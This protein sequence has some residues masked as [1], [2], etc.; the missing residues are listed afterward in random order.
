MTHALML[1]TAFRVLRI[2]LPLC[3]SGYLVSCHP[4]TDEEIK[5]TQIRVV[6]SGPDVSIGTEE[7]DPDLKDLESRIKRVK[8]GM[9]AQEVL[10]IFE[11]YPCEIHYSEDD[12]QVIASIGEYTPLDKVP[13][14][15]MRFMYFHIRFEQDGVTSTGYVPLELQ[16]QSTDLPKEV[17]E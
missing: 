7:F 11:G 13:A 5:Q 1:K 2:A 8:E 14:S 6:L 4:E 9:S 3:M 17:V 10:E 12:P 16:P 15:P